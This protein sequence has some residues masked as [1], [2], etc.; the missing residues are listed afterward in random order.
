VVD[1]DGEQGNH[2]Q[3]GKTLNIITPRIIRF[4]L[5]H[6][7]SLL[8]LFYLYL[9]H[10]AFD[11]HFQLQS[12]AKENVINVYHKNLDLVETFLQR[13]TTGTAWRAFS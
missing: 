8:L 5:H 3:S 13:S 9:I 2:Q 4:E 12:A 11:F 1:R 10:F 6:N 7:N